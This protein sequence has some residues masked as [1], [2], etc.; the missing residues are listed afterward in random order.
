MLRSFSLVFCLLFLT[1]STAFAGVV[2][3]TPD[4]ADCQIAT[5]VTRIG[6][7]LYDPGAHGEAG[8]TVTIYAAEQLPQTRSARATGAWTPDS[9]IA[10]DTVASPGF[11]ATWEEMARLSF[12]THRTYLG[13]P[14]TPVEWT[15]YY[16][17]AAD[18]PAAS[19]AAPYVKDKRMRA[20]AVLTEQRDEGSVQRVLEFLR[21][22]LQTA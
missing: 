3:I 16:S 7:S 13:L 14:G 15:D 1:I 4:P 6:R 10:L 9:R 8:A 21:S 5:T 20:L 12:K 19:A 22:K 11:A 2:G 17:I 18:E